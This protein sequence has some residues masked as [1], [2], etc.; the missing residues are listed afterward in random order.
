MSRAKEWDIMS[1]IE[2]VEDLVATIQAT[3]SIA[4]P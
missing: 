2:E 3:M 1:R 4:T